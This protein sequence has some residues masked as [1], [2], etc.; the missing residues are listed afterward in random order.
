MQLPCYDCHL[1]YIYIYLRYILY[2]HII[3]ISSA[4][5]LQADL[6]GKLYTGVYS[7]IAFKHMHCAMSPTEHVAAASVAC[8]AHSSGMHASCKATNE[9]SIRQA[10]ACDSCRRPFVLQQSSGWVTRSPLHSHL[11]CKTTQQPSYICIYIHI[12]KHIYIQ[13]CI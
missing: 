8:Q 13:V 4:W 7:R 6:D 1:I 12:Y 9:C 10:V 5:C 2:S 3:Y 11:L